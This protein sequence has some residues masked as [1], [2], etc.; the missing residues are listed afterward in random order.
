VRRALF[1][2]IAVTLSTSVARAADDD[3]PQSVTHEYSPYEK[4]T[5]SNALAETHREIETDP[6]GKIVEGVDVITLEVFEERD[7]IPRFFNVFHW[8]SKR[9]TVERELLVGV[10]ERYSQILVDETARNLRRLSSQL[11]VVL[12]VAVKG[13]KRGAVRILMITKDVWSLRLNSSWVVTN[14]GFEYVLLQPSEQ[15]VFGTHHV[16]AV[17]FDLRPLSYA[18]GAAYQI[19]WILDTRWQ[20]SLAAALVVNR[21]SGHA[22]GSTGNVSLTYPL[23]STQTQFGASAQYQWKHD[24]VRQYSDAELAGFLSKTAPPGSAPIPWQYRRD[25]D[26][27]RAYVVRAFG[28]ARKLALTVGGEAIRQQ[29][30]TDDLSAY[31]PSSR[32]EFLAKKVP[33]SDTRVGPFAQLRLYRTDY[34]RLLDVDLYGLQEDIRLGYDVLAKVYP[35]FRALGST[36]SFVGLDLRGQYTFT[37]GDGFIRPVAIT[38]LETGDRLFQASLDATLHA[39]A[40]RTRAG[41]LVYDFDFTR[42]FRNY[43]NDNTTLGGTARLRGYPTSFLNAP[44][45]IAQTLEWR[46]PPLQILRTQWGLVGFWDTATAFESTGDLRSHHSVGAGIRVLFPQFDRRVFRLDFG[47]P[48]YRGERPPGVSPF[49]LLF[50]VEQAFPVPNI[51]DPTKTVD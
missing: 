13:S 49:G 3:A 46:S 12:V 20:T 34:S 9:Y 24:V 11:S 50:S 28:W 51:I 15:N 4:E 43:Y 48:L 36:R 30:A 5:I 2:L 19:P 17:T 42:R 14:K 22:E 23:W 39:V 21:E 6:E 10:G 40:P 31:D 35:A 8:T 41:R 33:Q 29:Y 27:A 16:A 32:D 26:S 37:M 18:V 47:V 44:N 38:I 7:P 45:A 1:A 25:Y